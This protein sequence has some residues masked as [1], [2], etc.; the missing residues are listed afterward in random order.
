[1]LPSGGERLVEVEIGDWRER[2]REREKEVED[3]SR[4]QGKT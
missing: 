3:G 4:G 1:V 2:E